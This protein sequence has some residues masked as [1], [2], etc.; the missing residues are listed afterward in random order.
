MIQNCELL[1]AG[2][3]PPLLDEALRVRDAAAH[4]ASER[5]IKA[6]RSA[7][8]AAR[9]A[10]SDVE[11]DRKVTRAEELARKENL[12]KGFPTLTQP[13]LAT[14]NAVGEF[15]VKHRYALPPSVADG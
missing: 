1:R 12:S 10:T 14:H 13:G 3:L 7:I 15:K 5:A 9:D 11:W 4:H 2:R 8:N 6:C